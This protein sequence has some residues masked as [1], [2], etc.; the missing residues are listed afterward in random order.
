MAAM[1]EDGIAVMGRAGMEPIPGIRFGVSGFVGPYLGGPLRDPQTQATTY[2]GDPEDYLHRSAGYDLEV[3]YGKWRI[4]SEGFAADWEVP[5]IAETLSS[6]S[7]Y[8]EASYDILPGWT[9]AVRVGKS[10]Y[11]EISSTNDGLGAPTAWDDNVVQVESALSYRLAREVL[12]R[13]GWQHT[14]FTTGPEEPI[15]LLAAQVK[16]VF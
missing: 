13:I 1:E 4:F 7:A 14:R 5:L 6:W 11:S 12:L 10:A 9:P 8:G 3:S 2:P 15:N 16:A